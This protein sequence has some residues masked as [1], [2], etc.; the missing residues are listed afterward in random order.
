MPSQSDK[1][2]ARLALARI[3]DGIA[4]GTA[5][6]GHVHE[7]LEGIFQQGPNVPA[8]VQA[9]FHAVFDDLTTAELQKFGRMQTRMV[10]LRGRG[11]DNLSEEVNP[12]LSKF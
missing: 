5:Q 6:Q 11:Y 9:E 2:A 7:F 4:N 3:A 12:T 8:D 10:G 1:Q